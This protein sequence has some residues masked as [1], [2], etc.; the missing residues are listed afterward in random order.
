MGLGL[1]WLGLMGLD[2]RCWDLE[3]SGFLGSGSGTYVFSVS[4]FRV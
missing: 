1:R 2:F 4:G 3:G